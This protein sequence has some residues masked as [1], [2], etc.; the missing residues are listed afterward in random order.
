M[1]SSHPGMNELTD[2]FVGALPDLSLVVRRDGRVISNLGGREL[3]MTT[4][5]GAL[6]GK[7]L[8]D[9][10]PGSAANELGRSLRT[11]IKARKLIV[12]TLVLGD[13]RVEVRVTPHGVDRCFVII[14]QTSRIE[15]DSDTAVVDVRAPDPNDCAGFARRFCATIESARMRE[16]RVGLL[17]V[18]LDALP[19]IEQAHGANTRS[20]VVTAA[21]ERLSSYCADSAF[22][23]VG[24]L[25]ASRIAGEQIAV[26]VDRIADA[27]VARRLASDIRR[28]LSKALPIEGSRHKLLPS[29]GF[30]IYPDDGSEPDILFE[31]AHACLLEADS[32]EANGGRA[33]RS[34]GGAAREESYDLASEL[35]SAIEHGQLGVT[36]SPLVEL[37]GRRISELVA[38]PKWLHSVC[39]EMK[40]QAYADLLDSLDLRS[41]LDRWL[42]TCVCKDIAR[43]AA[44]GNIRLRVHLPIGRGWLSE[45]AVVG[46]IQA[47]AKSAEVDLS[48]LAVNVDAPAVAVSGPGVANI[49]RLRQLG[50]KVILCNFGNVGVALSRLGSL[51]LDG[52]R[53]SRS[54]TEHCDRNAL[55]RATCAAAGA[56]AR[57]FGLEC[58][59]EGVDRPT[60]LE[61]ILATCTHASGEALCLASAP[62]S[63]LPVEAR[64][65]K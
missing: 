49:R 1:P 46:E 61:T 51:P 40:L 20:M 31:R 58:I 30:A 16:T 33:T 55:S 18:N 15:P 35:R 2:T 42:L 12:S 43:A 52:V 28:L 36:Y 41:R 56:T 53:I 62:L 5:P 25:R 17:V 32:A 38:A 11:S 13:R 60:Q 34:V 47:I 19:G 44:K 29:V 24:S 65:A 63:C 59:A 22:E 26:L 10:W 6:N 21:A 45:A 14:R 48:R 4:V 37:E 64:G 54:V 8:E 57:A 50:M 7:T 9:L 23:G 3:G 39:G 27:D